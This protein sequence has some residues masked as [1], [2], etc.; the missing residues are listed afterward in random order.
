MG[1]FGIKGPVRGKSEPCRRARTTHFGRE[2]KVWGGG[3][4]FNG[5]IWGGRGKGVRK[6]ELKMLAKKERTWEE[7]G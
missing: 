1:G 5:D 7:K 4:V 3:G 2:L 6:K